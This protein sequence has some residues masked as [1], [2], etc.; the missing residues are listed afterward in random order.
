MASH[1]KIRKKRGPIA[2]VLRIEGDWKD[3][4]ATMLRAKPVPS[5][6]GKV[7]RKKRKGRT[8]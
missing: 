5:G 3:A 7:A 8:K 6:S 2:E 4:M 1:S